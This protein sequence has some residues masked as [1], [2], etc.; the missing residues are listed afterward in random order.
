MYRVH[1]F[2]FF[3]AKPLVAGYI[4]Q[5][6]IIVGKEIVPEFLLGHNDYKSVSG[7]LQHLLTSESARD[8][9]KAEFQKLKD[10][11]LDAPIPTKE[12][13][14]VAVRLIEEIAAAK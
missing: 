6:N 1:P 11:L 14:A 4:A 10:R 3:F 5:P 12:A 2:S 13:A 9:Q 8:I 7:A